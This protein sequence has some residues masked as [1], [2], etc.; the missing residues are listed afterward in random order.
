M[1]ETRAPAVQLS[2]LSARVQLQHQSVVSAKRWVRAVHCTSLGA[3]A[4]SV[5][6]K[7]CLDLTERSHPC[8]RLACSLNSADE[9]N[10]GGFLFVEI[11]TSGNEVQSCIRTTARGRS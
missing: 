4:V 6:G 5:S 8:S 1:G 3:T 9:A 7:F 2:Q 10:S 11:S